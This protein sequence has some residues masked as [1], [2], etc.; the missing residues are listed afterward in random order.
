[1]LGISNN[2]DNPPSIVERIISKRK[3]D[4]GRDVKLFEDYFYKES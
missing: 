1:L 2:S 4:F 3:Y